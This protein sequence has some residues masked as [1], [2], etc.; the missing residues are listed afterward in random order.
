MIPFAAARGFAVMFQPGFSATQE[1]VIQKPTACQRFHHFEK[2]TE[3]IDMSPT[4]LRLRFLQAF[5]HTISKTFPVILTLTL[6]PASL[7]AGTLLVVTGPDDGAAPI[8]RLF[9]DTGQGIQAINVQ[10]YRSNFRGG[11]RVAVGDVN[12]DGFPDVITGPGPGM[13][14]LIRVFDGSTG[15]RLEG[16]IGN[17]LAFPGFFRGGVYVATK[18]SWESEEVSDVPLQALSSTAIKDSN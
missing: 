12:G 4:S 15:K 14:P 9:I 1:A 2:V 16:H 13:E 10:P 5:N 17:F 7:T 6:F 3:E 8:V 18:E 11:V